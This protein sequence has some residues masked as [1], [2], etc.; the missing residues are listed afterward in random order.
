MAVN[1]GAVRIVFANDGRLTLHSRRLEREY[2]DLDELMEDL[3]IVQEN[4]IEDFNC[5]ED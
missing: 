5:E 1:I 2:E 4:M 3:K